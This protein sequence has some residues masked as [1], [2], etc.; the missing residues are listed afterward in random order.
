MVCRAGPLEEESH[1]GWCHAAGECQIH[2]G[3]VGTPLAE[4]VVLAVV[5]HNRGLDRGD[6][7]G[8]AVYLRITNGP[9]NLWNKERSKDGDHGQDADHFNQGEAPLFA[10]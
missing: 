3:V 4:G 9:E 6:T 5:V 1:P 7:Q 10:A 2:Q 8:C